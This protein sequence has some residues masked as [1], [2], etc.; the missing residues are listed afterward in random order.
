[1]MKRRK[2]TP[3]HYSGTNGVSLTPM[4]TVD[5]EKQR[6]KS[7]DEEQEEEEEDGEEQEQEQEQDEEEEEEK[8]EEEE[9]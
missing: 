7:F 3:T 8:K 2:G 4:S 9:K 6:G 5:P 1:M